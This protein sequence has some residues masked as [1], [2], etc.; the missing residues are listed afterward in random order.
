MGM[1]RSWRGMRNSTIYIDVAIDV[2]PDDHF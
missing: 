2:A 1:I